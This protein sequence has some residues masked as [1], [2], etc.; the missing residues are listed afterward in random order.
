MKRIHFLL[1]LFFLLQAHKQSEAQVTT[2]AF[3]PVIV[4]NNDSFPCAYLAD[5]VIVSKRS[6]ANAADQTRFNNLKYNVR[7]LYPYAKN[8]G[9][10][11]KEVQQELSITDS[12]HD[13]KKFL[14]Q[15]EDELDKQFEEPLKNLT[16]TQGHLLIKLIARETG[17]STYE[18]IKEFKNPLSAFFWNNAGKLWDY[19]LKE[20]YDPQE[21][22][23]IEM[24]VRSIE[25]SY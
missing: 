22:K 16:T 3:L 7:L 17:Q 24:I 19:D 1:I 25:N 6:F 2:D 4:V 12:R 23:D 11:F 14:K 9:K 8:A 10:I 21:D 13:R 18:L 20:T 5:V 15:K